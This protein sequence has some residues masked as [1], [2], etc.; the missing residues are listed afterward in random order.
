M[1]TAFALW[2]LLTLAALATLIGIVD[3]HARQAAWSRIAGDRR[4]LSEYR[5]SLVERE[6]ELDVRQEALDLREHR[7]TARER[8][9]SEQ[10][11]SGRDPKAA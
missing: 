5:D 3:G 10:E 11:R 9:S 7:L 8:A 1:I 4:R 2:G 6:S